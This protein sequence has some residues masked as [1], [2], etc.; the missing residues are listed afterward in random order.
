MQ[1]SLDGVHDTGVTQTGSAS[2]T[3]FMM[4]SNTGFN[5]TIGV[6]SQAQGSAYFSGK[7]ADFYFIDGEDQ[8]PASRF[9]TGSGAGTTYPATYTGG[10][11]IA[12]SWLTF[13]NATSAT[14]LGFDDAGGLP[15]AHVGANNWTLVNGP[16]SS[17]DGPPAPATV[18]PWNITAALADPSE[19]LSF[20]VTGMPAAATLSVGTRNADGSWSLTP[21]QVTGLSVTLPPG[22]FA[23]VATLTVTATATATGGGQAST[24]ARLVIGDSLND[25]L[26]AGSGNAVLVGGAG[27]D[28]ITGGAGQ[29]T[30]VYSG[31][32]SD[33]AISFS[34]G[35][36]TV[37]DQRPGTPDGT[38]SVS[39]V[40]A[41]QFADG[42]AQYDSSGRLTSWTII[43]TNDISG[44]LS[45]QTNYDTLGNVLSQTGINDGGS[46]WSNVYDPTNAFSWSY[47]T[48]YYNVS[49]NLVSHTQ[50]NDDGT[51]S[52]TGYDTTNTQQ[53]ASF[54]INYSVDPEF[55]PWSNPV[56]TVVNHDGTTTADAAES[57]NIWNYV[58]DTLIWYA[59]P[60][61][62]SVTPPGTGG[63]D[64]L[65]VILDLDNNGI[66]IVPLNMS[67]AQFDMDG[68]PVR[69]HTAWAGRGDGILAIDLGANGA[70][71]PDGVI[72]Q[73]KEINF[74]QWAPGATSDMAALRQVFDTNHNGMLDSGDA[75]WSDF[76]VWQDANS[77]GISQPGEVKTLADLG[78]TSI[79]LTPTGPA[80]PMA[81][82]SV[83]QG[84]S[85]F[86]RTDGTT[87]LAGDVALAFDPG[88]SQS[89]SA[90]SGAPAG[91]GNGQLAAPAPGEDPLSSFVAALSAPASS[92]SIAVNAAA[93]PTLLSNGSNA[94][95]RV[96]QLVSAMASYRDG[97]CGIGSSPTAPPDDPNMRG[98]VAAALH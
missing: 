36:F 1:I 22:S 92:D 87:G 55:G 79:D 35:T 71:D 29:D 21:A 97:D 6:S 54:T 13:A 8:M 14:T 16:V 80:Q 52:L 98:A 28:T 40:R 57:G 90:P 65:P 93:R 74:A 85:T 53:W 18:I 44:W 23:G 39:G 73:T 59:N 86:T 96:S 68:G 91:T 45:F 50:T 2:F 95:A 4:N 31:N 27:N 94:D 77:D 5:P 63:G 81:D 34:A 38:D 82:G 37:V 41:L 89:Q 60:F 15:G 48:N 30:A 3:S 78:I 83:I 20:T 42:T 9:V 24:S 64:G 26:V 61:V 49:H 58:S 43:N 33:Y 17:T 67:S 11:D 51:T 70:P 10:F 72:D 62:V 47:Y 66:N 76:R 84:T 69:E 32:R 12:G 56:L 75:L 25:T 46:S 19:A 88:P 7:I